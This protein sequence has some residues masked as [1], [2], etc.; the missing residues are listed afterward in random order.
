MSYYSTL[1][2]VFLFTIFFN[3]CG[4]NA[5]DFDNYQPLRSSGTLPLDFTLRTSV[6]VAKDLTTE[7][8]SND[9]RK[10]QKSKSGFLLKSNYMIDELLMSGRV[11][12][13]D[14]VSEYVNKVADKLLESEPELQGKLRFYCLKS[15]VTNAFTTNQGMIFITLGLISQLENEAQLAYIIAHEI[16]HYK[17]KHVINSYIESD[18]VFAQ[19]GR[20]KYNNYDDNIIRLSNYSKK[21]EFESDSVGFQ[22]FEKAGYKT[23]AAYSVFDVL[24]F[25]ELPY[26]EIEFDVSFLESKNFTI[27]DEYKLDSIIPIDFE[28]GYDDSKSTH[29][30]V[31][32]RRAKARKLISKA[33]SKN[34]SL[35][36]IS[37]K[38][39]F[40]VRERCRFEAIKINLK[41]RDYVKALYNSKIL[42]ANHPNSPYLER[43]IAKAL[44]GIFK[45]KSRGKYYSIVDDFDTYQGHISAA[46]FMFE[47]MDAK[48]IGSIA[49]SY[50]WKT[51][52][53]TKDEYVKLLLDDA[54]NEL[55]GSQ[56]LS[57]EM[58]KTLAEIEGLKEKRRQDS[59]RQDSIDQIPVAAIDSV[60]KVDSTTEGLSKYERL[61]QIKQEQEEQ[62]ITEIIEGTVSDLGEFYLLAFVG[63]EDSIGLN[64]EFE[65]V[66]GNIDE[67]EEKRKKE[68][69]EYDKLSPYAKNMF[70]KAE[71]KNE[72]RIGAEKIVIVDPEYFMVDESK[73]VKLIDS[74]DKKIE[75]CQELKEVAEFTD[76]DVEIISPKL[77]KPESI[78]A[79]NDLTVYNEWVG[80]KMD[81]DEKIKDFNIIPSESEYIVPAMESHGTDL[82]SYTGVIRYQEKRDYRGSV[83][84]FTALFY[85]TLPYGLWYAFT[86]K[87]YTYF[88]TF[89]Y[90]VKTNKKEID[91]IE[92]LR[93]KGRKGIINS[94]TYEIMDKIHSVAK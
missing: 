37:K 4:I 58:Y 38:G 82:I 92:E 94:Y 84:I 77:F 61:R 40:N 6:K 42:Q 16:T 73:G 23:K 65:A 86:P 29:P 14:P 89:V 71:K 68:E 21:L 74:E 87:Y 67:R 39:F 63:I 48:Q 64:K 10:V 81:H 76:L 15:N 75:F 52:A 25:S 19:K 7:I 34:K 90:N 5:Q 57:I 49:I 30:N 55:I 45:Y 12:F 13:G 20:Y 59:I 9:S 32:K 51:Y 17:N 88:Y 46:Y 33:K 44:Y 35:Y 60:P 18:R 54:V 2:L 72:G 28:G 79:Y 53:K 43:S 91:N 83:L 69:E 8:K 22:M 78:Q 36:I 24:Q 3:A 80:E 66:Q 50:L 1:K 47:E 26:D 70:L 85:P 41:N 27:P 93:V 56:D 31:D 11:L 62:E